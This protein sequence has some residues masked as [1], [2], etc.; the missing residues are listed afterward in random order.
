MIEKFYLVPLKSVLV[1][2]NNHY[3]YKLPSLQNFLHSLVFVV[4]PSHNHCKRRFRDS[5][6][7]ISASSK[8]L[9]S[10]HFWGC[11][12]TNNRVQSAVVDF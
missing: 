6:R 1:S 11:S 12:H 3:S 10:Q 5:A 4:N 7:F 8:V 9:I 2:S